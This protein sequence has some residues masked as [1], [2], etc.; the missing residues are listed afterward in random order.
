M[1]PGGEDKGGGG[2]GE[3]EGEGEGEGREGFCNTTLNLGYIHVASCSEHYPRVLFIFRGEICY[4]L[5]PL[6]LSK[7]VTE[8]SLI[9]FIMCTYAKKMGSL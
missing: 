1:G 4:P 8:A 3:V 2:G 9:V 6:Q 7:Y 5:A